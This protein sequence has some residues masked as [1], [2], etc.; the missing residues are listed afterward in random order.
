MR[1]AKSYTRVLHVCTGVLS[2]GGHSKMLRLWIESDRKRIHSVVLTRQSTT[3]PAEL[4]AAVTESGGRFHSSMNDLAGGILS[5]VAELRRLALQNDIVVLHISADDVI[6][7][8]AFADSQYYPPVL[9][10]NHADHSFWLGSSVAHLVLSMRDSA[11]QIAESRR[12]IGKCRSVLLP[13]LVEPTIRTID[14]A[15]AKKGLGL[16]QQC[17]L[18]TSVARGVKYR[19]SAGVTFADT[20]IPILK[21]YP[22]AMLIVV[23]AGD[24]HDWSRASAAVEGRIRSLP[25]QD[26]KLYLQAS[27]IYV[28]SYPF[29]SA[30]SMMEAAGYALP[31]VTRFPYPP[32]ARI[33]GMDH[34]GLFGP[35]I[36]VQS[37][38]EYLKQ[39]S[40]LI[41]DEMYRRRVG[42]AIAES[43]HQNNKAPSWCTF[44]EGA[45]ARA[46]ELPPV[47]AE[48]MFADEPVE[49][50]HLGEP[51]IRLQSIYGLR[52]DSLSFLRNHLRAL[53]LLERIARWN[54]VRK[55]HGFKD[56]RPVIRHL[57]AVVSH[58]LPEWLI[59]RL[60]RE[61][62]WSKP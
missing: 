39:L 41:E 38:E 15:E 1:L 11:M 52:I 56:D 8:I 3:V 35:S 33:C 2:V 12:S 55:K 62:W 36:E 14:R 9:Y 5:R 51:D 42:T 53:P 7:S 22:A 54:D 30:T 48:G 47:D 57:L 24:R 32:A 46:A 50:C 18:I 4:I 16:D 37:D 17:I 29:C 19:T 40:V 27:D 34:P 25:E 60:R 61:K 23:G 6:P 58:L 21:K 59:N 28:D 43:V 45:Y 49:R 13:I 44:L 26:P 10:L 31:C 20:H